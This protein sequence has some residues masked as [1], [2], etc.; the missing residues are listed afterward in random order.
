[1]KLK[2]KNINRVGTV[3]LSEFCFSLSVINFICLTHVGH[4]R[5][6][7]KCKTNVIVAAFVIMRRS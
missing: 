4:A 2:K 3:T 7:A 1:M 6:L 5:F